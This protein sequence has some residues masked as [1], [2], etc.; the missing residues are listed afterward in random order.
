MTPMAKSIPP[1]ARALCTKYGA[2]VIPPIALLNPLIAV[3]NIQAT[4]LKCC[5]LVSSVLFLVPFPAFRFVY[6]VLGLGINYR[7]AAVHYLVL[8]SSTLHRYLP[9][10]YYLLPTP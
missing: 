8:S 7:A 6:G 3:A 4:G 2:Q 5:A 10:L 9:T 1:C